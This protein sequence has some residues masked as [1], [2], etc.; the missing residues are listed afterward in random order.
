GA[1]ALISTGGVVALLLSALGLYAVVSFAVGKRTSEI[2]LRMAIGARPRQIVRYFA[3]DGLRL[4]AVGILIGLPLS[5]FGLREIIS[6]SPE[7]PELSLPTVTV[8]VT[9]GVVLVAGIATWLPASRAAR[10][11]PA[12]T[13]R[14]E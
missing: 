12:V 13:L 5:I 4:S 3:G 6:A 8:L 2:A 10:V 9:T 11:D 14:R 1:T 7:L